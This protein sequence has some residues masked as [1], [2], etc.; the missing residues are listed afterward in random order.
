MKTW[1]FTFVIKNSSQKCVLNA[2]KA[3]QTQSVIDFLVGVHSS[4]S[5]SIDECL[6]STESVFTDS[7]A[8]RCE[9]FYLEQDGSNG[10]IGFQQDSKGEFFIVIAHCE[11]ESLTEAWH[12]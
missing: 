2:P 10:N 4:G 6:N 11:N 3:L 1:T 8:R 9:E 5:V 7:N 12:I